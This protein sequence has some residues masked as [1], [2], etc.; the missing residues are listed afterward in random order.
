MRSGACSRCEPLVVARVMARARDLQAERGGAVRAWT[1]LLSATAVITALAGCGTPA[2]TA[3]TLVLPLSSTSS[4]ATTP[5][6]SLPMGIPSQRVNTF[7]ELFGRTAGRWVLATP[8]GVATNGGVVASAG[9]G[10]SVV[11]GVLPSF[12]LGFSTIATASAPGRPWA[13]GV[14]PAGLVA[15]PDALAVTPSRGRIAL[16]TGAVPG[17]VVSRRGLSS[18]TTLASDASIARA[19]SRQG[20]VLVSPSAV[21]VAPGGTI[22]VGGRCAHGTRLPIAV[23]KGGAWHLVR[24]GQLGGVDRTVLRLEDRAGGVVALLVSAA[25]QHDGV[26]LASSRDGKD[27]WTEGVALRV[28][29]GSSLLS[30]SLSANGEATIV[31]TSSSGVRTADSQHVGAPKWSSLGRLP[32]GTIDLVPGAPDQALAVAHSVLLIYDA[33]RGAWHV[34]QRIAVPIAYGSSG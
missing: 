28:P 18:W 17:L 21:T 4:S 24:G 13:S 19:T 12:S 23:F 30:T 34:V 26:V 2:H 9:P 20:C 32:S 16:L 3:T 29:S 15:T 31:L 7:W 6:A 11:A 1:L 14:L 8:P 5:W 25:A 27:G 33:Q 22:L 10:S